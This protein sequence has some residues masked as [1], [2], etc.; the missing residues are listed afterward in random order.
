MYFSCDNNTS[1]VH[2]CRFL[3]FELESHTIFCFIPISFLCSFPL[4]WPSKDKQILPNQAWKSADPGSGC[5][6][7]R[8]GCPRR[9]W[10]VWLE[11]LVLCEKGSLKTR[12]VPN[13]RAH[14]ALLRSLTFLIGSGENRCLDWENYKV[15]I[16][17]KITLVVKNTTNEETGSWKPWWTPVPTA[18]L[19]LSPHKSSGQGY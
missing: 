8:A 2:R 4:C 1:M 15:R 16:V 14:W 18:P 7:V 13:R 17:R 10:A 19:R 9:C 6:T 3:A 12:W 11:N 5:G